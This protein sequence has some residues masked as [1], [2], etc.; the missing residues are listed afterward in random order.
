M[1][2]QGTNDLSCGELA[3][4]VMRGQ[5]FLSFLPMNESALERIPSLRGT[6]LS[7]VKRPPSWKFTISTD[8]FDDVLKQHQG[9]WVWSPTQCLARL[10]VEQLYEVKHMYPES[11]HICVC[12]SLMTG[13]WRKSLGKIADL[14]FV[15][16][17]G[18]RLWSADMLE[19]LTIAF[20]QP[21]LSRSP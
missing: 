18:S 9:K 11:Q 15:V 17:A 19:S 2:K 10:A 13:Y 14:M 12:P 6:I 20:V 1:I 7:W 21:L 16:R 5:D 4:G 3:L 8:W